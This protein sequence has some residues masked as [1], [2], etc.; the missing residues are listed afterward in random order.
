MADV[1]PAGLNVFENQEFQTWLLALET[2]QCHTK[3]VRRPFVQA[4]TRL[5]G[6]LNYL[7]II[8]NCEWLPGTVRPPTPLTKSISR[9]GAVQP[10]PARAPPGPCCTSLTLALVVNVE[11]KSFG[12]A[13]YPCN[14]TAFSVITHYTVI[15]RALAKVCRTYILSF[16]AVL[17]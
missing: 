1:T 3:L 8:L 10:G 9:P 15:G 12:I 14:S 11:T 4:K 16:S 5:L 17:A 2:K 13:R 7:T 6:K